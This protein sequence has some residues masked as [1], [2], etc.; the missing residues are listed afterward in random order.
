MKRIRAYR[1]VVLLAGLGLFG[2]VVAYELRDLDIKIPETD[3]E[4]IPQGIH[5]QSDKLAPAF[6]KKSKEEWDAAV[7]RGRDLYYDDKTIST[8]GLYCAVCHPHASVSHPETYPKYK[9]QFDRVVTMQEFINWC[10]VV[11]QQGKSQPLGGEVLTAI[12]AYQAWEN[13]GLPLEPG[14]PGP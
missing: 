6:V 5:L 1:L 13:R 3:E 4:G 14:Y 11:P 12:E 7:V 8:N 9:Q 10:I 2:S